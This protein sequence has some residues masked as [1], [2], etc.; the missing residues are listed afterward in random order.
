MWVETQNRYATSDVIIVNGMGALNAMPSQWDVPATFNP[1]QAAAAAVPGTVFYRPGV[2][3]LT[4]TLGFNTTLGDQGCAS[5]VH[6]LVMVGVRCSWGS[7]LGFGCPFDIAATRVPRQVS[8]GDVITAPIEPDAMHYFAINVGSF[9]V[10]SLSLR[11]LE[12]FS[13]YVDDLTGQARDHSPVGMQYIGAGCTN[14]YVGPHYQPLYTSMRAGT[15]PPTCNPNR[16]NNEM[17]P[18][19]PFY[20]LTVRHQPFADGALAHREGRADLRR[21]AEWFVSVQDMGLNTARTE[22]ELVLDA[23]VPQVV[24]PVRSVAAAHAAIVLMRGEGDA[25]GADNN[26]TAFRVREAGKLQK[27][28]DDDGEANGGQRLMGCLTRLKATDVAVMVSRV[29]GGQNL[30]KVRFDHI[31]SAAEALLTELNH[32]PDKGIL[33]CWGAGQKVG[34]ESSV[35]TAA[36]SSSVGSVIAGAKGGKKRARAEDAAAAAAAE[37][38]ERRRLMAEAAERRAQ[39]ASTLV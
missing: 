15:T 34:G 33:H 9:D 31:C 8:D 27:A 21:A 38:V 37:A 2:D 12:R 1:T 22:F 30:G 32:L 7:M 29:Y 14:G 10:L 26:M 18:N 16:A 17:K 6:P 13:T 23:I 35:G 24:W 25:A 20:E 11:R 5:L 36:S 3:S 4:L 39:Q 28:Y 19:R